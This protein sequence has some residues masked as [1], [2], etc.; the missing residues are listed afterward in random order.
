[1]SVKVT[2]DGTSGPNENSTA[3]DKQAALSGLSVV[4]VVSVA[5]PGLSESCSG[6]VRCRGHGGQLEFCGFL[7][8]IA[9]EDGVS[10]TVPTGVRKASPPWSFVARARVEISPIGE[11]CDRF[12]PFW[13]LNY[14]L[15]N[16]FL[17][18]IA[19]R[20]KTSEAWAR[21]GPA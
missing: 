6:F 7:N 8:A 12:G 18:A 1:M 21:R 20:L 11:F 10:V 17:R 16:G 5:A 14:G 19:F 13:P 9:Y 2:A 15:D 4:S 3:P